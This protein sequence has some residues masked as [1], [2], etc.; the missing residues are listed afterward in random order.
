MTSG[1]LQKL[2]NRFDAT[3][4]LLAVPGRDEIVVVGPRGISIPFDED[5]IDQ[6]CSVIPNFAFAAFT[7]KHETVTD[8]YPIFLFI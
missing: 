2:H 8:A 5:M 1:F 4:R 7:F 6:M 3:G